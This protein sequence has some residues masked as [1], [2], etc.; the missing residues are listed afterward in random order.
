MAGIRHLHL[1]RWCH[2]GGLPTWTATATSTS[3][4]H[5]GMTTPSPG[6]RTTAQPT[7]SW[8]AADIATNADGARSVHVADM[9]GD[10]DLDIVS[11][12]YEDD[13]IAWYENDGAADPSWAAADIATNANGARCVHVAD[14]DGDG[15]LDIVSASYL[16][17][18]I[19]WY[20]NDGAADPSWAAADI[21]TN[22]DGA[23]TVY[24][25]D[26]DGDGDLDI[27]SASQNDD[28]IAWYENDGAADPSWTAT[29]IAT[30]ADGAF[31]VF[32]SDMDGDGDLDI[33]SASDNDDTIAWYENDGAADPSW[34][35]ADILPT[36]PVRFTLPTSTATATS[37]SSRHL[38][39]TTPSP[40]TRTTAQPTPHGRRPTS[41]PMPT[42]IH[43]ARRRHGQRRRPRHPL[44]ISV[45]RHHR[46]VRE[47]RCCG[48]DRRHRRDLQRLTPF[49][50]GCPS[51][52]ARAPS[53]AR[54]RSRRATRP[55]RS[56]PSSAV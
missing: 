27:V 32:A 28:T 2:L 21:A 42:A 47:R 37:T 56:P 18:T 1:G 38:D 24:A 20:E 40:G 41:P 9:D 22:A 55:T 35:A 5:H 44:G 3:S 34:A 26:M 10:G 51:T 14:M 13:T 25:A 29:D 46:L 53:A 16:D 23:Q 6:T 4:Q 31:S 36:V 30:S 17:D 52:A 50:P 8:A 15:D 11:A 12:S 49:Q 45:R 19:A 33:V 7:P 43:S 39:W 48:L 54:R